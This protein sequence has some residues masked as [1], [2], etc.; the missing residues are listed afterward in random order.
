L[1]NYSD[2][3]ALVQSGPLNN[4]TALLSIALDALPSDISTGFLA[5]L[6]ENPGFSVP[7]IGMDLP[8]TSKGEA[9]FD[10]VLS[11]IVIAL[12]LMCLIVGHFGRREGNLI[13]KWQQKHNINKR[14]ARDC[15]AP[16]ARS[17]FT[18][19]LSAV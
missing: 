2:T 10:Y 8:E 4:D 16:G 12:V 18:S 9:I 11:G 1:D 3:A 15:M 7:L 14:P 5:C 13:Y 6:N 19:I 17:A